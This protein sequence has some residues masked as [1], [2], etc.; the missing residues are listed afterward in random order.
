MGVAVSKDIIETHGGMIWTES[1]LGKRSKFTFT[2]P[3]GV[4]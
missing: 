2:I 1:E 4:R 3:V